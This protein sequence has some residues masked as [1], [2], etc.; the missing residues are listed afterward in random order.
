M[1]DESPILK[2]LACVDRYAG[3]CQESARCAKEGVVPFF[4]KNAT[5]IRVETRKNWVVD[6]RVLLFGRLR[7]SNTS[8][9]G[10]NKQRNSLHLAVEIETGRV[11]EVS[12]VLLRSRLRSII[13]QSDLQISWA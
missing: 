9:T 6:G 12:R 8:Q 5:R 2:I 1:T 7:E 10:G 11:G 4:D 3:K 13:L